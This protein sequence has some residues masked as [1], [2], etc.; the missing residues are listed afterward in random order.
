LN[1]GHGTIQV[2]I[3]EKNVVE[4]PQFGSQDSKEMNQETQL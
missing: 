1:P 4:K 3:N 2:K